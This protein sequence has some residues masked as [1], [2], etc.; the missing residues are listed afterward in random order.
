MGVSCGVDQLYIDV[1]RVA[2][3][4]H[5]AFQDVGDAELLSNFRKIRG[6]ALILLSRASGN[7]FQRSDLRQSSQDFVLNARS[8]KRIVGIAT[9]IVEWEHRDRSFQRYPLLPG[10]AVLVHCCFGR[11]FRRGGALL[12]PEMPQA[13]GAESN[14]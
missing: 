12:R 11:N 7:D 5:T 2:G 10:S 13:L 14:L 3:F 4:L 9:E 8:E 1:H 6:L